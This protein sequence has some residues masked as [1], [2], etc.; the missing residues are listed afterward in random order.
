MSCA[1]VVSA[2]V[3][4]DAQVPDDD[5]G[6]DSEEGGRDVLEEELP[7][8]PELLERLQ[9]ALLEGQDVRTDT[10]RAYFSTQSAKEIVSLAFDGVDDYL[11]ERLR[12]SIIDVSVRVRACVHP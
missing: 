1:D 3:D 5:S 2:D 4:Q 11:L 10:L 12:L 7:I 8:G 9:K 6:S